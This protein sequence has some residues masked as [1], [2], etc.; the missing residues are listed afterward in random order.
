MMQ[1]DTSDFAFNGIDGT[2]GES[3][4][5]PASLAE[6]DAL[7][8]GARLGP[9]QTAEHIYQRRPRASNNLALGGVRY[10]FNVQNLA[11]SGWGVVFPQDVDPE[12]CE[13]LTPLIEHRQQ[14]ATLLAAHRFRELDYRPGES[15]R[16][17][18]AR[19]G[20][21]PSGPADPDRLPYYLL[22]VGS[23]EEIPWQVQQ[24][25]AVQYGV[26]RLC[27]D[28]AEEYATYAQAVIDVE[29]GRISRSRR[30]V[31]FGS[32]HDR[33]TALMSDYLVAP[34]QK[35][36][37]SQYPV[38]AILAEEATKDRLA[39]LLG[40]EETPAL[41]FT[42]VHGMGFPPGDPQQRARQGALLCQNPSCG[43]PVR[44]DVYRTGDDVAEAAR[45]AGLVAFFFACHGAGTPQYDMYPHA[46]SGMAVSAEPPRLLAPQ[47]F[48]A[49]LP[50]RLLGHPSG[51][52][53]AV[54]G[55]VERTW[56]YS[57]L[58]QGMGSQTL[59]FEDCL[60]R[61]LDGH[62]VGAALEPFALRHGEL[63]TELTD[64]LGPGGS[65]C[66]I[67][68]EEL[69]SLWTAHNDARSYTLLG[70]PAVRLP[71]R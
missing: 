57:F 37:S 17:F 61:L 23:P 10:G 29:K 26:G 56:G 48:V 62:P 43:G 71:A 60:K 20:V 46:L 52:A 3:F 36:L 67:S 59:V 4:Y 9:Q 38:E 65:G 40:G 30:V 45:P 25:L 15:K 6:M 53:L 11:D 31:L 39:R 1:P 51:G 44:P 41:L 49:S 69:A 35:A 27:F 24:Q 22:L 18:L 7:V 63:A 12:I 33:T 32:R 16:T 47:P 66:S 14:Q 64:L 28:T 54:I 50:R 34:L 5:P 21:A 13:A 2:T 68:A 19:Y 42:A 8:R 70:D 55:H 58:W